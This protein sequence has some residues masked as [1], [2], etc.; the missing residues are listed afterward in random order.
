MSTERKTLIN[1]IVEMAEDE[2]NALARKMLDNGYDPLELLSHCR[3]A[4]DIVGSRYEQGEYFLPELMMAGEMLNDISGIA[5]PL[6]QHAGG[7]EKKKSLGTIVLGTVYGD[8]H[9]IG[10]NIVTFMLEINGYEVI[11]LGIDVPIAE[12]ISAIEEHEPQVV[13]LSG[14]LTLAFDSMKETVEAI[15]AA[16]LRNKVKIMIGGGQVDEAIMFH[17]GADA[18]GLNALTAVSLCKGWMGEEATT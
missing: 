2:A 7:E 15:T 11:D 18:F 4:M 17:T 14:F 12:F 16:G 3:E 9:D 13:A 5:K 1:Y 8:L 6:I 10:K